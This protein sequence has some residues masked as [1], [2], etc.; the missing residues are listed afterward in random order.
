MDCIMETAVI[1]IYHGVVSLISV[2]Y[3]PAI[4]QPRGLPPI[5]GTKQYKQEVKNEKKDLN[6]YIINGTDSD[7]G[8]H[9]LHLFV[10]NQ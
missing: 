5:L 8:G 6:S 3:Q 4:K 10:C 2:F 1:N 7:P 9:R